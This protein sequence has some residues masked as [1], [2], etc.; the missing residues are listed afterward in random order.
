MADETNATRTADA[1]PSTLG[2]LGSDEEARI[3]RLIK[4]REDQ[5]D[6]SA[7]RNEHDPHHLARSLSSFR[8]RGHHRRSIGSAPGGGGKQ[9][10]GDGASEFAVDD[11]ESFANSGSIEIPMALSLG[12]APTEKAEEGKHSDYGHPATLSVQSTRMALAWKIPPKRGAR[13]SASFASQS[14]AKQ[15][16]GYACCTSRIG[17]DVLPST[18]L[19]TELDLGVH[20]RTTMGTAVHLSQS[21]SVQVGLIGGGPGGLDI[22]GQRNFVQNRISGT[23]ALTLDSTRRFRVLQIGLTTLVDRLPTLSLGI[24]LGINAAPI[25]LTIANARASASIGWR[26]FKRGLAFDGIIRRSLSNF[27]A[28]GVG[29]RAVAGKGV[30]WLFQ[31]E[32]GEFVMKIPV[33]ICPRLDAGSSIA[34]LYISF[35]SGIIDGIIGDFTSTSSTTSGDTVEGNKSNNFNMLRKTKAKEDAERQKSLMERQAKS[36]RKREQERNGLVI[37]RAIYYVEGGD[38]LDVAT[39]IQFW[40]IDSS[41]YLPSTPKSNLLGFYD[42]SSTNKSNSSKTKLANLTSWKQIKEEFWSEAK[43]SNPILYIRYTHEGEAFEVSIRDEE[44]LVLPSPSG[45]RV[46]RSEEENN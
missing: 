13:W 6:E 16:L 3:D 37:D 43:T 34:L 42:V 5:L 1:A 12:D 20:P 2:N 17:Y 33:A 22:R 30:A 31:L 38:R 25:Q 14:F 18:Q 19:Y 7:G 40:V 46:N 41:L 4:S 35:L 23:L 21:S 44:E 26:G 36:K 29:V 39:Q 45:V 32:R 10:L 9:T 24:N 15:R 11:R 27:A 8:G 28:F